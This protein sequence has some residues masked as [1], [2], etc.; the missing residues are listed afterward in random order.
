MSNLDRHDGGERSFTRTAW[1]AA[2][3]VLTAL[4][5]LVAAPTLAEAAKKRGTNV[6]VMTR[7]VFLGADLTPALGAPDAASFFAANGGVLREVTDTDFPRRARLLA[8][9]IRRK[10]PDL[11]GLQEVA[12]WRTAEPSLTPIFAGPSAT[13]VRFDFLKQLLQRLNRGTGKNAVRYRRAHVQ[14]EFDF[15]A[16]ADENGE[17]DD[18]IPGA[19][20]A[21]INGRLTM[22]DVILMRR[23]A[24][25]EVRNPR[26]GHYEN[27]LE[28]TVAEVV[29]VA[30]TRGWTALNARVRGGQRFRFVNTHLEAF[31]DR[32]EIPSIRRLQAEEVLAGPAKARIPTVLLGDLNSDVPGLVAGDEQAFEAV[33]DAGFKRRSTRDPA[34][35][36]VSDLFGSPPSEFDHVVDHIT[37]KPKRRVRTLRSSVTGRSQVN[38]IYP[39]DHAGVFSRLRIR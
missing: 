32:T 30:V 6:S 13:D 16:P 27:L 20:N 14:R 25:V 11:V 35:C 26:G 4:A 22:R 39:S 21:E 1:I 24:G 8:R 7:N 18:G 12:L 38:G 3:G 5:A 17:P 31:D 15:E 29:P 19:E 34:S 36:C 37:G 23:K 28:V 9:E 33:L 10:K 2:L